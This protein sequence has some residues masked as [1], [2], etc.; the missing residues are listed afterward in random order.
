MFQ[1]TKLVDLKDFT[2]E[3]RYTRENQKT[4]SKRN[5]QK[6]IE[7][8][9]LTPLHFVIDYG[10]HMDNH[11]RFEMFKHIF[12]GE[13]KKNEKKCRWVDTISLGS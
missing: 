5:N 4:K 9:G 2:K 1:R 7:N 13:E 3:I 6:K 8:S 10:Y 11:A 12:D